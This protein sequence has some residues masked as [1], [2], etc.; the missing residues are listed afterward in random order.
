MSV[1][2]VHIFAVVLLLISAVWA[3]ARR[4]V[5]ALVF[6]IWAMA[7]VVVLDGVVK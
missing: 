7:V 5:S 4:E 6:A 1:Y 2:L 3:I